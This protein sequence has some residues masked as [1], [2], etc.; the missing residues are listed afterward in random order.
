M[1]EPLPRK[2]FR[3]SVWLF[4]SYSLTKL[5]RMAMM[6]IVAALL[7]PQEYGIIGLCG[8][9]VMAAEII[10]EFGI[11]STVVYRSNLDE[12]FLSTAFTMNVLNGFITATGLFLA[13]PWI[14]HFY[15]IPEIT[16]FLR[17]M[18]VALIPKGIFYVPD[19]L[20]RKELSFKSRAL[21]E[22]AGTFAAVVVTVTL[23]LL[24]VGILSY[25]LGFVVEGIFRCIF[26]VTKVSRHLKLGLSWLSLR[27]ISSYSKHIL[28]AD[29]AKHISSNIDYLIVGSVLGAGPLG[30]YTLAF[31][32]ANY[33]VT[34]F[35]DILSRI[36]FP[37]FAAMREDPDY[38]RRNYLNMIQIVAALV[39]PLLVVLALLATPI[40]VGLLG[41]KWQPAVFPLQIIAVAG[42]SRAVSYPGLDMLR[43]FGFPG[44]PFKLSLFEGLLISG[45]LLLVASRGIETVALSVAIILSL[46]SWTATM[47]TCWTF[48][49]GRWEL[50]RALVPGVA[51]AASAAVPIL[52]LRLLGVSLLPDALELIVLITAASA[53]IAIC[54][55][56]ICRSHLRKIVT[57]AAS[58]KRK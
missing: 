29:V 5:G 57:L 7:S 53:G 41:E 13:A 58:V 1:G 51:L 37:T 28:G 21:P 26:T 45:L 54:L 33:P 4:G 14:A 20:L 55:A 17:I 27:E 6:L 38:A 24:G 50:G 36:V 42:I 43:A 34:N 52:S 49:I 12:R 35:A 9:I 39:T 22:I 25:A 18:G 10:N 44:I 30:L 46:T 56:T 23:L 48:E 11:W 47:I 19:G 8:V 3:E 31:N 15:G 40:I 32:L 2:V 16:D